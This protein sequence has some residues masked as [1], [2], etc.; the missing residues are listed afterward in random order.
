MN[1]VLFISLNF[2]FTLSSFA[3]DRSATPYGNEEDLA[4]FKRRKEAF[5]QAGAQKIQNLPIKSRETA[6]ALYDELNSD[7]GQ[8]RAELAQTSGTRGA[9]YFGV[10]RLGNGH[11]TNTPVHG[12]DPGRNAW[13][14]TVNDFFKSYLEN[15]AAGKTSSSYKLGEKRTLYFTWLKETGDALG[16]YTETTNEQEEMWIKIGRLIGLEYSH[17][18][19]GLFLSFMVPVHQV[20]I[21]T[22]DTFPKTYPKPKSADINFLFM[23]IFDAGLHMGTYIL[24]VDAGTSDDLAHRAQRAL[25]QFSNNPEAPYTGLLF[26]HSSQNTLP[27]LIDRAKEAFIDFVVNTDEN[28][29]LIKDYQK[30]LL[31]FRWYKS[32][33]MYFL[34]GSLAVAE[35]LE[36]ILALSAS[37]NNIKRS[38]NW[39]DGT[40]VDGMALSWPMDIFIEEGAKRTSFSW[41]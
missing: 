15:M 21:R 36:A 18:F 38:D 22:L 40:V 7:G 12:H 6:A 11:I 13:R 9:E 30:K 20:V 33:E 32:N 3:A 27:K 34:R 35:W 10:K 5:I 29:T 37:L 25:Q 4:R 1:I 8:I 31:T 26:I 39:H 17:T 16:C 41:Q 28:T 2:L 24:A 14:R 23:E 19:G